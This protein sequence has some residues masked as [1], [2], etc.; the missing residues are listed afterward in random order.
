MF[1]HCQGEVDS[2]V[3]HGGL[4]GPIVPGGSLPPGEMK[5]LDSHLDFSDLTCMEML[6]FFLTDS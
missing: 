4:T 6:H 3:P 2:Q 1:H 5:V